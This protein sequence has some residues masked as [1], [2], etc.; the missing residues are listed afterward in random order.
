MT[1]K[2]AKK[3]ADLAKDLRRNPTEFLLKYDKNTVINSL[4]QLSDQVE[5]CEFLLVLS[6][7]MRF[8]P[9]VWQ[10]VRE[11][12]KSDEPP[13]QSIVKSENLENEPKPKRRKT[14]K[15]SAHDYQCA[16]CSFF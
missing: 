16:Q 8:Y 5:S 14:G 1:L 3:M 11:K 4:V 13:F 15:T 12:I 7:C 10:F 9:H 2:K 6:Q